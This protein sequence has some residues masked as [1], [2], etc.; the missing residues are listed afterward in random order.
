VRGPLDV[1]FPEAAGDRDGELD[2]AAVEAGAV[3]EH[4]SE[5]GEALE[6]LGIGDPG[7]E[8]PPER[9]IGPR[10]AAALQK[11]LA[12]LFLLWTERV[13]IR[14]RLAGHR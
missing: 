11:P 9:A 3:P 5:P 7:I 10:L 1:G 12:L 4:V 8:R 13:Q 14:W 2:Q 6:Q